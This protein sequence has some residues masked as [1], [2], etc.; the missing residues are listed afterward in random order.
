MC[1]NVAVNLSTT[2]FFIT[3]TLPFSVSQ[4][5]SKYLLVHSS[6]F[7]VTGKWNSTTVGFP[8]TSNSN[9]HISNPAEFSGPF[10]SFLSGSLTSLQG[11]FEQSSN[12]KPVFT[13]NEKPINR[14]NANGCASRSGPVLVPAVELSQ[15]FSSHKL[16]FGETLKSTAVIDPPKCEMAK[17]AAPSHYV[18]DWKLKHSSFPRGASDAVVPTA[19]QLSPC[20]LFGL[21]RMPC[22]QKY[23]SSWS[24]LLCHGSHMS[25]SRFCEQS[26]LSDVNP[27]N[28]VRMDSGVNIARWRKIRAPEDHGGCDWPEVFP[29]ST[30]LGEFYPSIPNLSPNSELSGVFGASNGAGQSWNNMSI[31]KNPQH[32]AFNIVKLRRDTRP[33]EC[34]FIYSS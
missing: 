34:F 21:K 28:A 12:V 13:V 31:S 26:G 11:G 27:G 2:C 20:V 18:G 29:L 32:S 7:S 14:N 6:R 15:Y 17:P 5:R 4:C 22:S 25:I 9:V 33:G 19:E 16:K 10:I 24:Y 30:G 8:W 3:P 23:L 1:V